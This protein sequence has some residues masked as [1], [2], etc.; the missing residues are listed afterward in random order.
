[1][2][3]GELIREARKRAGLTQ[4]ELAEL[5][6]TTQPVIARWETGTASPSFERVVEAVRAC[7]FDLAVRIVSRDDEHALW[8]QQ[9]LR[10]TPIERLTQFQSGKSAIDRL[11]AKVTRREHDGI[12]S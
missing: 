5:L 6:N 4:R 2:Y 10:L 7:G 12:Q 9:N 11:T 1:M 3:G 8:V